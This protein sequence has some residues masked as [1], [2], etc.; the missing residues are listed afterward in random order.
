MLAVAGALLALTA[1]AEGQ[2]CAELGVAVK[3]DSAY[4]GLLKGKVDSGGGFELCAKAGAVRRTLAA[5][6]YGI[7]VAGSN[8]S[9]AAAVGAEYRFTKFIYAQLG[10]APYYDRQGDAMRGRSLS[11]GFRF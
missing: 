6:A 8:S 11:V 1:N 9:L 5:S 3:V 7:S 4:R 10:Y 2:A